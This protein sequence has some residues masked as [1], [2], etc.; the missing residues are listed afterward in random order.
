MKTHLTLCESLKER[1]WNFK[2]YIAKK[3]VQNNGP[4]YSFGCCTETILE[5]VAVFW[6]EKK[7]NR[8][9]FNAF[10][11][12][13]KAGIELPVVAHE[14]MTRIVVDAGI[15]DRHWVPIEGKEEDSIV[16]V[17]DRMVF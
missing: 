12:V 13:I 15:A 17:I 5:I 3:L 9:I 1:A 2:N 6:N 11:A 14:E 16:D 4:E 10:N 8:D 7:T